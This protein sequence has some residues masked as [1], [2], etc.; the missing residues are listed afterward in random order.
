[1]NQKLYEQAQQ[2]YNDKNYR[3]AA[4]LFLDS[5]E[6]GTPIGN[7][8][9]C[10]M[11]GNA[12]MRLGRYHDAITVYQ[13]ALRDDGYQHR[14]AIESNLAAA[15]LRTG[16]YSQAISFYELALSESDCVAPYKCYQGI[17]NAYMEQHKFE[18]AALA[19]KKAALDETNSDPGKA[20]VNLGLCLMAM[21][22]PEGASEAYRAALGCDGYA[23]R[24]R[25]LA[26]LGMA[27]YAQKKWSEAVK[28]FE[29]A[30]TLHR[31]KLSAQ[32][33]CALEEARMA[34]DAHRFGSQ[35]TDFADEPV[36]DVSPE[37]FGD[38]TE[39]LTCPSHD[40]VVT[41]FV[42]DEVGYEMAELEG[43]NDEMLV[44]DQDQ[45]E[46]ESEDDDAVAQFFAA[47]EK[48]LKRQGQKIMRAER[49]PFAWLKSVVIIFAVVAVIGLGFG[50]L[51]W[52]GYGVPSSVNTVTELMDAYNSGEPLESHWAQGST[53]I[54]RE[55]AAIP[56][57]GAYDVLSS[58]AGAN[59]ATVEVAVTPEEGQ[60]VEFTF[61]LIREG[62]GWKISALKV[63][64]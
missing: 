51:Y 55:M 50:Y 12:F 37:Q 29:E 9:A 64:F 44:E 10:Y 56:T 46:D 63:K 49:K 6:P 62:L 14:C 22:N 53:N 60:K 39:E 27:Y 52:N 15:Y 47:D 32:G 7:G 40:E 34:L 25:A 26:N 31:Y 20:L 42:E 35:P 41:D 38:S 48:D 36:D 30:E 19:Y 3:Q 58:E 17:A 24:G 5:L 2:E 1:M 57:P 18:Q 54:S 8:P 43:A 33:T 16:D 4:R 11:A 21:G 59:D 28:A 45:V 61:S 23:N 13:N